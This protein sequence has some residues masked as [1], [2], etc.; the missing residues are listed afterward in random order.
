M[1]AALAMFAFLVLKSTS[2]VLGQ[3]AILLSSNPPWS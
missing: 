3:P 1:E 2:E